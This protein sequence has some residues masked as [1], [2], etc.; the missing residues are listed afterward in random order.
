MF[1]VSL[2]R[3]SSVYINESVTG[4]EEIQ[5]TA[6]NSQWVNVWQVNVGLITGMRILILS[7][8]MIPYVY[9]ITQIL[10]IAIIRQ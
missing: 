7:Y 8:S 2:S 3:V 10:L 6:I 5:S 9:G 1:C 4:I